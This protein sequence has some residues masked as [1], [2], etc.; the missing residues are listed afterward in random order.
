MRYEAPR[1][2]RVLL[3]AMVPHCA[4]ARTGGSLAEHSKASQRAQ[5]PGVV[6]ASGAALRGGGPARRKPI[7]ELSAA[8]IAGARNVPFVGAGKPNWLRRKLFL[9]ARP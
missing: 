2:G 9:A 3:G 6:S 8:R 7:A 5:A 1:I 4:S